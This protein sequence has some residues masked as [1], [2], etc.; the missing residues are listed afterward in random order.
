MI[1]AVQPTLFTGVFSGLRLSDSP[2]PANRHWRWR[3]GLAQPLLAGLI[4]SLT[5]AG[6]GGGGGETNS[7]VASGNTSSDSGTGT[8]GAG[9]STTA[10]PTTTALLVA[11]ASLATTT[12]LTTAPLTA[13]AS[14]TTPAPATTPARSLTT[15]AGSPTPDA[16]ASQPGTS[17]VNSAVGVTGDPIPPTGQASVSLDADG[18]KGQSPATARL[19]NGGYAIAWVSVGQGLCTRAYTANAAPAGASTCLETGTTTSIQKPAI[20]GLAGGGYVVA[21]AIDD[22][23]RKGVIMQRFADAGTKLGPGQLVDTGST[24]RVLEATVAALECGD[25]VVGWTSTPGQT[26][27]VSDIYA[28][29]YQADGVAVSAAQRVNTFV[30]GPTTGTRRFGSA[31]TGLRDGGYVFVWTSEGQTTNGSEL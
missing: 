28:R 26:F 30:G 22:F 8:T 17:A 29:R 1:A 15:L 7:P 24:D 4:M 20:A 23:A 14:L 5:L 13:P 18:S 9:S 3:S 10:P 19:Q 12:P 16:A 31:V 27:N 6:C 2:A 21:F 11:P 25:F